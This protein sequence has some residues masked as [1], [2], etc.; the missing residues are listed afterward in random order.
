[1]IDFAL[2]P[3]VSAR[4]SSCNIL[5][6]NDLRIE[7]LADSARGCRWIAEPRPD[8]NGAQTWL[9]PSEH[10]SYKTEEPFYGMGV[11]SY[12]TAATGAGRNREPGRTAGLLDR[13][14]RLSP[15]T[16]ARCHRSIATNE[17]GAVSI[18]LA[19]DPLRSTPCCTAASPPLDSTAQCSTP[20]QIL[21]RF[22]P[23]QAR[24]AQN[25][26]AAEKGLARVSK[27]CYSVC[28]YI[29]QLRRGRN[30]L[31]PVA[32]KAFGAHN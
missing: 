4:G 23:R 20:L 17:I 32:G 6:Q 1:M 24:P 9:K 26:T 29:T 16:T 5:L 14:D 21:S 15:Q 10:P 18:P 13:Y 7:S 3:S 2:K 11:P 28:L 30:R 25:A 31:G 8:R 22:A 27:E 12:R 19:C